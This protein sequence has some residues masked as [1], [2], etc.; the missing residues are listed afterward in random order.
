[1]G[2]SIADTLGVLGRGVGL[3]SSVD[4]VLKRSLTSSSRIGFQNDAVTN[5]KDIHNYGG[6]NLFPIMTVIIIMN[7]GKE[8]KMIH[9]II[10]IIMNISPIIVIHISF[11][12]NTIVSLFKNKEFLIVLILFVVF[13]VVGVTT[14]EKVFNFNQKLRY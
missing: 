13:L 3:G 4:P 11:H 1:M 9:H 7:H 6:S 10:I 14:T 12:T 5:N 8:E 2:N